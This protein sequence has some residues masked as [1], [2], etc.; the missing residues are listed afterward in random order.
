MEP[1]EI[2]RALNFSSNKD[3]NENITQLLAK[4]KYKVIKV[5]VIEVCE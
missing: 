3:T 5:K 2:K 4:C 1:N